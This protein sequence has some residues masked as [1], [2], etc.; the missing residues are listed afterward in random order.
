MFDFR[1]TDIA[2]YPVKD[3]DLTGLQAEDLAKDHG[4]QS[5]DGFAFAK[6][7]FDIVLSLVLLPV[8]AVAAAVLLVLNPFKNKGSLWFVQIRMGK[9]CKAFA[10]IKFRSMTEA[11]RITRGADDPLETDRISSLGRILR[12]SRIDELPQII[13]VLKG[14][15]SLIGPRPDYFHHARRYVKSVPGY[16]DRHAVRPGISGLAQT[17]IGYVEG[18]EATRAKV[19]ADI[20][21]IN[22]ACFKLDTWILYRTLATVLGHKGA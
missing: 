10:A 11:G 15:M 21:Y 19:Q 17:E 2:T 3:F 5:F 8:L 6:R 22:N 16:R 9:D 7:A 13:N 12:K 1:Q 20:Y 4:I 14:E 18:S